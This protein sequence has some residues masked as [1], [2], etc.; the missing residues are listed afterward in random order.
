MDIQILAQIDE[1]LIRL[2]DAGD[3]E[4]EACFEDILEYLGTMYRQR[5]ISVEPF[6]RQEIERILFN[7]RNSA[8]KRNF[9]ASC[10][11]R[12][13]CR[14]AEAIM[15]PKDFRVKTF[16]FLDMQIESIYKVFDIN[17]KDQN[18]E[19]INKLGDAE[20]HMVNTF[21]S[22]VNNM[23]NLETSVWSKTREKLMK[24]LNQPLSLLFLEEPMLASNISTE[25][26][27]QIFDVAKRYHDSTGED[28][29]EIFDEFNNLYQAFF[30][31]IS[32]SPSFFI[33]QC[34]TAPMDRLKHFIMDDFVNDDANKPANIQVC[35][36][37][38]KYPLHIPGK[39]LEL[40]FIVRNEGPGYARN[41][42]VE[43]SDVDGLII[44][45]PHVNLGTIDVGDV[46]IVIQMTVDNT[47]VS[48]AS[49]I[50][51]RVLWSDYSGE[52]KS[53]DFFF[54]IEGQREDLDWD[55]LVTK[56][57]YS[58]EAVMSEDELIGRTEL[59]QALFARLTAEKAESAIIFGQKRVGKT[60]IARI[61]QLKLSANQ[62]NTVIFVTTGQLNK[63]TPGQFVKELGE[64]IIDEI[65]SD[66]RFS[67]IPAPIIEN[68]LAPLHNFFKTIKRSHPNQKFIIIID[69]F[70]EIPNDL[71]RYTPIGDTFFHNIRSISIEPQIGFVLVGS[72]N[73]QIIQQTT[74]KLNKF[75]VY[76]VDYFDKNE[77]WDDFKELV[78]RPV[79][80]TLEYETNAIERIYEITEGNPF[81]TKLICGEIYNNAC[82]MR[83][84]FISL[85]ET[86]IAFKGT[87]KS[88]DMVNMNHFWK[89]G[90]VVDEAARRD[91]I[92][93][94]RRKLL[95]LYASCRLQYERC[96]KEYFK[97]TLVDEVAVDEQ[98]EKFVARGIF[99]EDH[100][101]YRCKPFFFDHWLV[102]YGARKMSS[103]F[104]DSKAIE[105]LKV[106]ESESYVRDDELVELLQYWGSYR[107]S[108]I[109][110]H[111][112]NV[113]LN[114]FSDNVERRLMF[115]ILQNVRFYNETK[116]RELLRT[117]HQSVNSGLRRETRAGEKK[118]RDIL[119]SS[120]G[121]IAKSGPT[122]ARKYANENE[123]FHENVID[124]RD[125]GETLNKDREGRV[126]AIVF[127]DDI[128]ATGTTA[129]ENLQTLDRHCG[130][131]IMKKQVKVVLG[132]IC[133][134]KEGIDKV[135]SEIANL[136]FTASCYVCD[137]L[138]KC[139]DE[140]SNIFSSKAELR[141]AKEITLQYGKLLQKNH[142]L[143]YED[144]QL[145]VVFPDNCPNNTLPI[146]SKKQTSKTKWTP[147]FRRN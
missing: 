145:L 96:D 57:P 135:E 106:K 51:G 73:M 128:V 93:T 105:S 13:V 50:M 42:Q 62:E 110:T 97:T 17:I 60:S 69:E 113:W 2:K 18:H 132:F 48:D 3:D 20:S 25:H 121:G 133:G 116:I 134:Q 86:E 127:V 44:T 125:I 54:D 143:G 65:V 30:P 84:A 4:L 117:I 52:R 81:F 140:D 47:R 72:E 89:D 131:D 1:L 142:P 16:S 38:R 8:R 146:L 104:L 126:Q 39:K 136:Q 138:D 83:N 35:N 29:L 123:V 21:R 49:I 144:S 90:I 130:R 45:D 108:P 98:I 15:E 88:V 27:N 40:Y 95:I 23:V 22:I 26:I 137:P 24:T 101:L 119:V 67:T 99:L 141:K 36:T 70:D 12:I 66:V 19:K 14:R 147:L 109:T 79:S 122:Y 5:D 100:G 68:A 111:M 64:A 32:D 82:R 58:L 11:L 139:F 10:L 7:P 87:A 74:D 94:Q 103:E 43:I 34:I 41:V 59:T 71:Y 80:N 63:T 85:E 78:T 61:L 102:E 112:I 129:I 56:Q 46:K 92:E 124:L 37:N 55:E 118:R 28:R 120:F 33:Q 115:R 91:E 107:S 9:I 76:Q 6:G 53:S 77:Y 31:N 75:S 114:Q